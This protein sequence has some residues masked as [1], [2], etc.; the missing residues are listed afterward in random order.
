MRFRNAGGTSALL[1][2]RRKPHPR[3]ELLLYELRRFW[4][5]C[6]L[7]HASA[8]QVTLPL[9]ALKNSDA[10]LDSMNGWELDHERPSGTSGLTKPSRFTCGPYIDCSCAATWSRPL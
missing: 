3:P 8:R 6:R 7:A 9:R 2:A 5:T 10:N 4:N 1:N